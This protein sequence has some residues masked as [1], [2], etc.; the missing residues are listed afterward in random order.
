[1]LVV[2]AIIGV[3]VGLLLPAVQAARES[4]RRNACSSNLRQIGIAFQTC[5]DA[6][7]YLPAA[8]YTTASAT[9][10]P[11][12]NPAGKEHSW[13]VLVMPFME[14]QA[15]ANAYDWSKHWYEE[16]NL[17]TARQRVAVYRCPSV[18]PPTTVNI[19]ASPD[20]DSNRPALGSLPLATTDYEVCTGLKTGLLSPNPYPSSAQ[21]VGIVDKDVVT[22]IRQVTD[23]LSKTILAM[24]CAARPDTWRAQSKTMEVNQCVGWA[25]SLGPFKVDPM[26]PNGQKGAAVNVGMPMN[27]AND[28][29]VY[30]FHPGTAA[31]VFGDGATRFIADT[32]DLKTF[33]ALMTRTAGDTP[34]DF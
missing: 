20:S 22:P 2:I 1:M 10:K 18:S 6:K 30:S 17:T 19:P 23:G 16:P 32:V 7:K 8:C 11:A 25:D 4:A 33:C 3:L 34:G 29:E 26:L 31:F 28:G 5:V 27:S 13:R 21:R 15:I 12:Q 24:E 9:S 14:E